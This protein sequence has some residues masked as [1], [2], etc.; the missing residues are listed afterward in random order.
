MIDTPY[1]YK[2]LN[3]KDLN[4]NKEQNSIINNTKKVEVYD[5]NG[6]IGTF[7]SIKH[8][9]NALN[10]LRS[11]I[12]IAINTKNGFLYSRKHKKQFRFKV[13]K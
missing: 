1:N 6:L 11:T 9:S 7:N 10:I 2:P 13:I 5:Y 8:A 4:W 12:S 3:M